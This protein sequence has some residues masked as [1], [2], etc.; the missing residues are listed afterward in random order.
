MGSAEFTKICSQYGVTRGDITVSE[1]RDKNLGITQF[2]AR[3]YSEVLGRKAD[4]GGLNS[5]C[6]FILDSANKKQA[7][8]KVASDG[9]FNSKEYLNK[10]TSNDE[11]VR[12]LYRTFL[13]READ[14][15]GYNDWM[16]KLNSGTDRKTVMMGF[17][18]SAEFAKIMA[19]YGI[20]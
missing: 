7:A 16:K 1:A 18:N 15:A 12:T 2:V 14:Q 6:K 3:C 17:A 9:F 5:W 11:Y 13:G 19:S 10:N 8:I 20:K 4:T